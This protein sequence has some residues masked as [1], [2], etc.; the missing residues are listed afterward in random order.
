MSAQDPK[1]SPFKRNRTRH[2]GITY[3]LRADGTRRYYVYA[4]GKDSITVVLLEE[5]QLPR[6]AAAL[7][8]FGQEFDAFDEFANGNRAKKTFP[9]VGAGP[10]NDVRVGSF[11]AQFADSVGVEQKTHN[12]RSRAEARS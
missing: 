9:V 3:R 5:T 6:E 10:R 1:R 12:S 7:S 2:S 8:A 4:Q 11:L